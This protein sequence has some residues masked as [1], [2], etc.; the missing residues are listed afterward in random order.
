MPGRD[1]SGKFSERVSGK[2]AVAI[3]KQARGGCT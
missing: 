2:V 3:N 1:A